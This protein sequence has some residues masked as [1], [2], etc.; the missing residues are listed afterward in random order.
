LSELPPQFP[1]DEA[2]GAETSG[3]RSA[4]AGIIEEIPPPPPPPHIGSGFSFPNATHFGTGGGQSHAFSSF[5]AHSSAGQVNVLVAGRLLQVGGAGG[6]G[7]FGGAQHLGAALF[8]Q[9]MIAD[10]LDQR[11][12]PS[13][14]K[15]AL[16]RK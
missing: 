7:F 4:I 11:K 16:K 1:P 2:T 9:L 14:E 8:G 5:L 12:R 3:T 15:M 6:Q 13:P 10:F